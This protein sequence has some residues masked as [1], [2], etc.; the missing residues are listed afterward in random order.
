M[1][2][3][4]G[5]VFTMLFMF[6]MM[7]HSD[8]QINIIEMYTP[9]ETYTGLFYP[10]AYIDTDKPFVG[11]D[12]FIGDPDDGVNL[13]WRFTTEGDGVETRAYFYPNVSDCPG[14][15]KGKKYRVAA[16]PWYYDD[17]NNGWSDWESRDFTVF[18][19]ISTTEVEDPPKKVTTVYGYA[20][21]TRQYY[22]GSEIAIDCYVYASNSA[23]NGLE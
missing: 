12:W 6:G 15:V 2:K 4:I 16:R 11:V 9:P 19:S 14:H 13:S 5:I 8:A 20:E 1:F 17:D 10:Y 22:T 21:L 18:Q 3:V 23:E 7:S